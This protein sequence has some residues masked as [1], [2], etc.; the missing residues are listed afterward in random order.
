VQWKNSGK[1][2]LRGSEEL[3]E[4]EAFLMKKV[5]I[6]N[7]EEN[8]RDTIVDRVFRKALQEFHMQ[9][10]SSYS[11][12]MK[13]DTTF[14]L[15]YEDLMGQFEFTLNKIIRNERIIDS[16]PVTMGVNAFAGVLSEFITSRTHTSSKPAKHHKKAH[17]KKRKSSELTEFNGHKFSTTQFSIPTFCE[18]CGGF[19]WGLDKGFVCQ[20]C[21]FTCHKKCHAKSQNICRKGSNKSKGKAELFGGDLSCLVTN[22]NSVPP[23]VDKLINDIEKRGLYTEG[24]Y[25]K[26]PSGVSV[27]KLKNDLCTLGIDAVNLE[28]FSVHAVAGVL[29]LFFRQL[30]VPVISADLYMDFMRTAELSEEKLRLQALYALVQKLPRA[31][32]NTLERL[33]FHLARISQHQDENLMNANALSIIWAQ[34]VMA[35]PPGM[36]ALESMQD[37]GKQTRCL[38]TLILG[39][40]SKIRA[41]LNNIRMLDKATDTAHKRLSVLNL[42]EEDE[43]LVENDLEGEE[44]E[45]FLL[46]QQL[47]ELREQ[48]AL[49]TEKLTSLGPRVPRGD[50]EEDL[51]S[52]DGQTDDDLEGV[53]EEERREEYAVTFDLPATPVHLR[54]LTKNRARQPAVKRRRPTRSKLREQAV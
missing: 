3:G 19:I 22:E 36:S 40:L 38:E 32:R 2:M 42:N 48:R 24:L 43:G 30:A 41:T 18:H 33:V 39:Q 12:L 27:K 46:T 16:F 13:G 34:C 4:L 52:D 47:F 50:S 37:V 7:K 8:K 14:T 21:R 1:K 6:L 28:E 35:T 31:S 29:K 23:L 20:E 17:V 45:K 53:E 11:V 15:K 10:I 9:L 25:R 54:H 51:A 26:S 44:Q 5:S 49:L